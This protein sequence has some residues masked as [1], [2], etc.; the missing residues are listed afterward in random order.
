[1]TTWSHLGW[2]H[3]VTSAF[4]A[5]PSCPAYPDSYAVLAKLQSAPWNDPSYIRSTLLSHA[6]L[7]ASS[8]KINEHKTPS[9]GENGEVWARGIGWFVYSTLGKVWGEEG[10]KWTADKVESVLRDWMEKEYGKGEK[11]TLE[12][13]AFTITVKKRA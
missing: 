1:L 2:V 13:G 5:I 9:T 12:M 11:I 3:P 7:D 10:K 8:L 4:A 6:A